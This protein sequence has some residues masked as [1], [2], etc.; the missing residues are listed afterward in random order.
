M[1]GLQNAVLPTQ[2]ATLS[3]KAKAKVKPQCFVWNFAEKVEDRTF[4]KG[5]WIES[6]KFTQLG[7]PD[8]VLRLYPKGE[9]GVEEGNMSLYLAAC[10]AYGLD[11][12][13][14]KYQ[15]T[16]GNVVKTSDLITY[17][18]SAWEWAGFP[19][20]P[21]DDESTKITVELLEAIPP[22]SLEAKQTM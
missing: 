16:I 9:H 10:D 20:F 7:A 2:K 1:R 18:G 4:H 12:W 11:G 14:I 5:Q 6:Q 21:R 8:L 3:E 19:D 22:Q 15:A 13:Q 17:G